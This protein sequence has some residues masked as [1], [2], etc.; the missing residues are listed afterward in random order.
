VRSGLHPLR[1]V[2][3]WTPS[4]SS[5]S[6]DTNPN[7]GG[8]WVNNMVDRGEYDADVSSMESMTES[9]SFEDA[10]NVCPACE[11]ERWKDCTCTMESLGLSDMYKNGFNA[12]ET[13]NEEDMDSSISD[14][15]SEVI[16]DED[17][18]VPSLDPNF[19][20]V[21]DDRILEIGSFQRYFS[22]DS[23][24]EAERKYYVWLDRHILGPG[25]KRLHMFWWRH[26]MDFNRGDDTYPPEN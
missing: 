24:D 21:E 13:S 10:T 4:S 9:F 16:E 23:W 12:L 1:V 19:F 6:D 20:A 7:W 15:P 25:D 14:D 8:D 17:A 2:G 5:S 18:Y 11:A 22:Y 26:W 3:G